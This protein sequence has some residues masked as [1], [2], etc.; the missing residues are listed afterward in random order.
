M[1]TLIISLLWISASFTVKANPANKIL[2]VSRSDIR[3]SFDSEK[4]TIKYKITGK[5]VANNICQLETKIP[6]FRPNSSTEVFLTQSHKV[7]FHKNE[8]KVILSFYPGRQLVPD[9]T[10]I[11]IAGI[12]QEIPAINW[13][14]NLSEDQSCS[15]VQ[16]N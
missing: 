7:Y 14:C 15:I 12:C 6:S 13:Q 5:D 2:N 1:R 3:L 4:Y 10:K 16:L 9:I 11:E 8:S